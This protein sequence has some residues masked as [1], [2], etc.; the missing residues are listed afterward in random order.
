MFIIVLIVFNV[1]LCFYVTWITRKNVYSNEQTEGEKKSKLNE[2][3][4]DLEK[5]IN[6]I[7]C[8]CFTKKVNGSQLHTF[9][10]DHS[11]L[12]LTWVLWV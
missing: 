9:S 1:V 4:I 8:K 2:Q 10:F 6:C 7:E 3:G 12:S 5:K 11:F